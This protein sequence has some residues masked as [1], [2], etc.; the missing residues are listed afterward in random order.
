MS[1][2]IEMVHIYN[3]FSNFGDIE[4]IL[5]KKSKNNAFIEYST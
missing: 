3:L 2:K 5:L 4:K 1:D